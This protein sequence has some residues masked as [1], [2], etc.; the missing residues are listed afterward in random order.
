MPGP[1][2][3]VDTPSL[4]YRAYFALPSTITGAD[5]TPV[6]ELLGTANLVLQAVER[7]EPRA[8]TLCWGAEA[9]V[10]R[11]EAYPDYHAK[12]PEMPPELEVQW[13][14]APAFFEAF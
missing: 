7:H 6:N 11:K 1:L 13:R 5:G 12:R 4:M 3:V 10:Y 2:L 8:V 9:A 14:D